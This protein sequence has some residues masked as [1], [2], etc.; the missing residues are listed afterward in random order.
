MARELVIVGGGGLGR[1]TAVLATECRERFD[2]I[3][4]LDDSASQGS[5]VGGL[6]VLG[7]LDR[8]PAGAAAAVAVGNPRVRRALVRRLRL[9]GVSAFPSLIHRSAVIGPRVAIG[10]GCLIPA[11]TVITCDVVLDAFCVVGIG[12]GISHDCRLHD[13]TTIAPGVT[14]PGTT[15]MQVGAEIAIGA[16]LKQGLTIGRGAFLAMG[17]VLTRDLASACLAVG[18][19][20]RKARELEP[21]EDDR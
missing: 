20:A 17:A 10:E 15:T 2:V 9:A 11:G 7:P 8:P 6:P 5:I 1:E 14:L 12:A 4:I 18:A 19:P 16:T 13:F 21:W 3:G